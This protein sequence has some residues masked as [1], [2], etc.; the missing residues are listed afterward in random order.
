MG[1]YIWTAILYLTTFTIVYVVFQ[2]F[3]NE[4]RS[5]TKTT[6]KYLFNRPE[7]SQSDLSPPPVT[8]AAKRPAPE[9]RPWEQ[10]R[11]F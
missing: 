1:N 7:P 4:R 9:K 11:R 2:T 3:I 8:L 5:E 6:P 10:K